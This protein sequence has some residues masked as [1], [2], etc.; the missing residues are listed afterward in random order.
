M[1][2]STLLV[3]ALSLAAG[4]RAAPLL[5]PTK[6]MAAAQVRPSSRDTSLPWLRCHSL[7]HRAEADML[8]LLLLLLLLSG[9]AAR[10]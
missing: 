5:V 7:R 2:K 1:L 6:P 4:F 3:S 8:L 9:A 10:C